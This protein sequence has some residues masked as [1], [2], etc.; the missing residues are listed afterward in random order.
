MIVVGLMPGATGAA[1]V[2]RVLVVRN[3]NSPIS[4][5]V[6]DDYMAR[7][8]ANH[9]LDIRVPDAAA[10][11]DGETMIFSD[12]QT[13]IEKP[14]RAYLSDHPEIDF[15]LLTKGVPIR[16]D[17]QQKQHVSLD[18]YI[19]ALDYDKIPGA[20]RIITTSP[21]YNGWAP[22]GYFH[23]I[24]WANRF[25]NSRKPFSHAEFGGY[26]VTRLDGYTQADAISLTTR[27]LAA[28]AAMRSSV[29]PKGQ[30]LLDTDPTEGLG[31]ANHE[32]Y[33]VLSVNPPVADSAVIPYEC[34]YGDWNGDLVVAADTLKA[35]AYPYILDTTDEFRGHLN[36][37]MGYASW[38]S[39]DRHFSEEAYSSLRFA[40][41]SIGETAVSTS[42]RHF[43][44]Y[45][46]GGQTKVAD[47]IEGGITGVK[48]YVYEPLLQ[49]MASP[50]ILFGR[51]TEGWT[52]AE[53]FYAASNEVGWEDIIIGDPILR[54]YPSANHNYDISGETTTLPQ[55]ASGQARNVRNDFQHRRAGALM[56]YRLGTDSAPHTA[57]G[58][59]VPGN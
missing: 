33:S 29:P 37:L 25:W 1:L 14:L 30:F 49:A 58:R 8:G 36:G 34:D 53:S 12:F 26:L 39:N 4:Q 45:V 51:Y 42:A 47:L 41:G 43:I 40:P 13:A 52:L 5:A 54:A 35:H 56:K 44:R 57:L 17:G 2:D 18:S 59:A 15:I 27:S 16:L 11:I 55:R 3:M 31:N 28:E 7:R 22:D 20:I 46:D 19:A 9:V 6:A 38:G 21:D 23:G 48:G 24:S 50:S 32:P 10:S